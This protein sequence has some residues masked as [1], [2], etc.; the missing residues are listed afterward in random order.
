MLFLRKELKKQKR[1]G[2]NQLEKDE[3]L[4][5]PPSSEFVYVA[6]AWVG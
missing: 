2:R 5:R 3:R 1:G 6:R 4:M